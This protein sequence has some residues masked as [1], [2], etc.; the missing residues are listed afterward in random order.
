MQNIVNEKR[1]ARGAQIGKIATFA[2]LGFLVV[3]LIVSLAFKESPL[4][5]ISF[6]CLLL[7]LLGSSIG[8]INMGRWVREPRADQAL[9][10]GLKGFDNRY[11]L[12][13]Y[14]LPAPHVL[15]GPKGL[16]VF[17][18]LGQG[19][20]IRYEGGNLRRDRSLRRI[21]LFMSEEG[22]GR[23]FKE[24]DA[25][26]QALQQFLDENGVDGELEIDNALVFFDPRVDLVVTDPPRP[27]V[28]PKGLKRAIRKQAPKKLSSA[29]Y[30]QLK[31]LF[32]GTVA[33]N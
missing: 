2:G 8:S 33:Q 23:P 1:I 3:G 21:L 14:V 26:V 32:E 11:L 15:L 18:M 10:Q 25:Q 19:G 17:T 12:Y 30:Q 7:G 16:W 29:Q 27:M 28:V 13:N 20:T 24:A 22:M 31:R 5:L 4:L 9:V 6:G